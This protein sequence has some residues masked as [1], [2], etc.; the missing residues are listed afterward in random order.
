[1]GLGHLRRCLTI[2]REL[3][4]IGKI[5]FAT[6]PDKTNL[7]IQNELFKFYFK[8]KAETEENFLIRLNNE[9]KPDIIILDMKY[10][11]KNDLIIELKNL[12]SKIIIIDCICEG[13]S[14][15]D[16]I[17]FPI[18]T[19]DKELLREHLSQE[20]I[21]NVKSGPDYVIIRDEIREL[22]E[23]PKNQF[24]SLPIVV[25]T[26][27][28][29]DPEGVLL[30][31]LPWLRDMDM[32][33]CFSILVGESFKFENEIILLAKE[34]PENF[35]IIPYSPDELINADIV[36]CTFGV[37]I[38]E[39][40]FL[41]IPTICISHS[42]ENSFS[43]SKLEENYNIIENLGFIKSLEKDRLYIILKNKLNELKYSPIKPKVLIDGNGI[44]RIVN[45][46]I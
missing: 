27:G 2:A 35:K 6:T 15:A 16:E 21:K 14:S 10:P 30:K 39:M 1:V 9:L 44:D 19:L 8:E 17:I 26:T 29:S 20:K 43:A 38:Y 42:L 32:D 12:G 25:V 28:G 11:Y 13:L 34:L 45:L 22:K 41:Q 31:I 46:I 24:H 40:I 4:T 23:K 7:I 37:S 5:I 3:K 33:V 36:I 18:I